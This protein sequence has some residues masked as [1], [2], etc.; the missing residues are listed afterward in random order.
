MF[1][2]PYKDLGKRVDGAGNNLLIFGNQLFSYT[3]E[4]SFLEINSIQSQEQ[5]LPIL[6]YQKVVIT[7]LNYKRLKSNVEKYNE[8][9]STDHL[10]IA[11]QWFL[12]NP[13]SPI[14]DSFEVV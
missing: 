11:T 1:V 12:H 14:S 13:K 6:A 3:N 5:Q 9:L 4:S 2:F 10:A 7:S 8:W